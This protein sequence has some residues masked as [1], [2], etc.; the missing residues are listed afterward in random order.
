MS[1]LLLIS[2]DS[3]IL[4]KGSS[5]RSRME[6]YASLVDKLDIIALNASVDSQQSHLPIRF[7]DNAFIYPIQKSWKLLALLKAFRVAIHL[8][9]HSTILSVQDPFELGIFGLLI[10]WK[11]KCALHV[12]VHIDFF[13][14]YFAGES[15]RSRIQSI[16]APYVLKRADGV[17]AV[18]SR[19]K[20]YLVSHLHIAEDR[21][22][23]VPVFV[24]IDSVREVSVTVDL[25]RI[26][27]EFDWIVLVAAR[28]VKQKNIPLAI[29]AFGLFLR[30]VEKEKGKNVGLVIAGSGPE[31]GYIRRLVEEKKMENQ[32][33]VGSWTSDF[34]SC[35]KTCDVF[36]LSSDYEGW[37][38]TVM[39]AASLGK[40][41]IMTDVESSG[42]FI[43][44]ES[45][46]LVVPLR[47]VNAMAAAMGRLYREPQFASGLG[48]A[49]QAS[50]SV[51]SKRKDNDRLMI[52]SWQ[53]S[54]RNNL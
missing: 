24:N 4:E 32:V 17:R 10:R 16:I 9:D 20:K 40:P 6:H 14:P 38:R 34:A 52:E 54:Q 46:G 42:E 23:V 25:H 28:Y 50:V 22:I 51:F 43:V 53:R 49:A 39:E 36:L 13:S 48:L 27:P 18:S 29:S 5:A 30:S 1:K 31:E 37:V 47:D 35:M 3:A 7:A 19:I 33:K 45:N 11:T 15:L 12:Q 21:V 2:I 8:A 26:F 41:I 44:N